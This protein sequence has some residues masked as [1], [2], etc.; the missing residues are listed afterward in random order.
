MSRR[1]LLIL[2]LSVFVVACA[3]L[4]MRFSGDP[5]HALALR[6]VL[7]KGAL[8]WAT[9]VP[10][11]ALMVLNW[12][13][14]AWKWHWLMRPVQPIGYARAMAATVAGTSIGLITPN[15]VGEFA[16]R[17]LFLDPEHRIQGGFATLLG[18]IAQFVVTLLVGGLLLGMGLWSPLEASPVHVWR[19]LLWC[20][21]LIG[22]AAVFLYFNPKALARLLLAVPGLWRFERH[23][24]VLD[25][26]TTAQL[27]RVFLLSLARYAVF[28]AQ[29]CIVLGALAQV[30][31]MAALRAVP[32][33]FLLTTLV[34]TMALTELGVR[35]SVAL[36]FIPGDAAGVLASTVLIWT[37]NLALPAI[38]GA[39]LLVLVRI[40]TTGEPA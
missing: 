2:R 31:A 39:V 28:T 8:P 24:H 26:F 15:R 6:N 10:V 21:L 12:G 23:A 17:V 3:F 20:A 25:A 11:L 37:I 1:T 29:F 36:A 35:G 32:V 27:T 38:F 16:G 4:W 5:G 14:E 18:S 40:R 34:P 7:E 33:V 13:L 19:V 22:L 9:L 30:P